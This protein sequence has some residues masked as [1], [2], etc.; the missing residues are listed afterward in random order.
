[1]S[2]SHINTD[3]LLHSVL[4]TLNRHLFGMAKTRRKRKESNS[5]CCRKRKTIGEKLPVPSALGTFTNKRLVMLNNPLQHV[6][7]GNRNTKLR[8]ATR[9]ILSAVTGVCPPT[10]N[11]SK[12]DA[13]DRPA[14]YWSLPPVKRYRLALDAAHKAKISGRIRQYKTVR[15]LS[16]LDRRS[17]GTKPRTVGDGGSTGQR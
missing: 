8:S 3:I 17:D 6:F 13:S 16:C 15:R 10:A 2:S 14:I 5:W 7:S 4:R 11:V 12:P 1:M 9:A